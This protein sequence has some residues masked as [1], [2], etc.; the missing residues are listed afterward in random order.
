MQ[1]KKLYVEIQTFK[2]G[3]WCEPYGRGRGSKAALT[4]QGR[5]CHPWGT[6]VMASSSSAQL[7]LAE[8]LPG[9]ETGC[10]AAFPFCCT[11]LVHSAMTA[12][13]KSKEVAFCRLLHSKCVYE[14]LKSSRLAELE[15]VSAFVLC[16]P[17]KKLSC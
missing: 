7:L 14:L 9:D 6:R 17:K 16:F 15:S 11:G 5:L 10:R 12:I 4:L 3:S 2:L 13:Q 1:G 8:T